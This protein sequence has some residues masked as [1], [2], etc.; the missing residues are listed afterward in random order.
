MIFGGGDKTLGPGNSGAFV[1]N[2]GDALSNGTNVDGVLFWAV[3]DKN[4]VIGD[5]LFVAGVTGPTNTWNTKTLPTD[6]SFLSK[7]TNQFA[8]VSLEVPGEGDTNDVV[9]RARERRCARTASPPPA[10]LTR[11]VSS[12]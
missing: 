8:L 6:Y 5:T 7:L 12:C 2:D 4:A 9:S 1:V 3:I 10:R 11:L